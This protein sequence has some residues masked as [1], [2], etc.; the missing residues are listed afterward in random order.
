VS[1]TTGTAPEQIRRTPRPG[2]RQ[3]TAVWLVLSS[4]LVVVAISL[5]AE[6]ESVPGAVLCAAASA[7]GFTLARRAWRSRS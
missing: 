6:H 5:L 2:A 3:V 7:V 4:L 1:D